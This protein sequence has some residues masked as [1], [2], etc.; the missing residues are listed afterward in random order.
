[1]AV[2]RYACDSAVDTRPHVY[3]CDIAHIFCNFLALATTLSLRTSGEKKRRNCT[4]M[5]LS[6]AHVFMHA[7]KWKILCMKSFAFSCKAMCPPKCVFPEA[8]VLF[9]V[10][11]QRI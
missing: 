8:S 4:K 1:M 11:M 10:G 6:S 9:S 2:Y 5:N 3:S 7:I